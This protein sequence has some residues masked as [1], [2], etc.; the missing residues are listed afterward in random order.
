MM[1]ASCIPHAQCLGSQGSLFVESSVQNG[2][3]LLWGAEHGMT[4][5]GVDEGQKGHDCIDGVFHHG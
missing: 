2:G 1:G 3:Q 5:D 4:L